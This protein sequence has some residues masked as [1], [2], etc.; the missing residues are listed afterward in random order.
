MI[1]PR[2]QTKKEE[3]ELRRLPLGGKG[4]RKKWVPCYHLFQAPI[5]TTEVLERVEVKI[6][7]EDEVEGVRRSVIR[8]GI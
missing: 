5:S 6:R 8:C 2:T 1:E 4:R 7:V 3:N